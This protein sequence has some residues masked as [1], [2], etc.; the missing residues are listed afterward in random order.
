MG[1]FSSCCFELGETPS[2]QPLSN[3]CS[4]GFHHHGKIH[5]PKVT[6]QLFRFSLVEDELLQ[7]A[8]MKDIAPIA[9]QQHNIVVIQSIKTSPP[10]GDFLI[11]NLHPPIITAPDDA[12]RGDFLCSEHHVFF[13]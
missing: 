10:H 5:P 4:P 13:N 11:N 6:C 7:H 2:H 8:Y 12:K 9:L 3:L 1:N